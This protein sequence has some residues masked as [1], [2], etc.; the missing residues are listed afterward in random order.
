L[1]EL[2]LKNGSAK[3]HCDQYSEKLYQ[4]LDNMFEASLKQIQSLVHNFI[5]HSYR[6]NIFFVQELNQ[7][8]KIKEYLDEVIKEVIYK[9]MK[10][11]NHL[12]NESKVRISTALIK[13][14]SK[15]SNNFD[16]LD[17]DEMKLKV[18]VIALM[19]NYRLLRIGIIQS[20]IKL[21]ENEMAFSIAITEKLANNIIDNIVEKFYSIIKKKTNLKQIKIRFGRKGQDSSISVFGTKSAI[22]KFRAIII[23]RYLCS[24]IRKGDFFIET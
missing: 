24:D 3:H 15:L 8:F 1:A 18:G 6:E 17:C 19:A 21:A 23:H 22:E 20:S 13:I 7:K 9:E 14:F 10:C 11:E 12:N 2:A 5:F 4:S 16:D